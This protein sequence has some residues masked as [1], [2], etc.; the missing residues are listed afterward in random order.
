MIMLQNG[1]AYTPPN[2]RDAIAER[3][4]L[5]AAKTA[6]YC[7]RCFDDAIHTMGLMIGRDCPA[8]APLERAI[9][10]AEAPRCRAK[11]SGRRRASERPKDTAHWGAVWIAADRR[12]PFKVEHPRE[13]PRRRRWW[14]L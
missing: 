2:S 13:M 3:R 6:L 9:Q 4:L 1:E 11:K 5:D 8:I 12:Q 10:E 7:L 14:P